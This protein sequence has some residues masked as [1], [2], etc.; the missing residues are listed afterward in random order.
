MTL[1]LD[2]VAGRVPVI[3]TCSHFSTDIAC[4]RVKRAE[5]AGAAMVMM[6]PPYHG[7]LL[8]ADDTGVYEHFARLAEA[9]SIPIM[10]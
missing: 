3:V 7:A 6:M 10:I 2:H 5:A 8:R 4:A 9:I 1:C